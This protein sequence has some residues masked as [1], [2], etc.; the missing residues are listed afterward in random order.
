[1]QRLHQV[2]HGYLRRRANRCEDLLDL[3]GSQRAEGAGERRQHVQR[4]ALAEPIALA[5]RCR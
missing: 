3:D 5:H 4:I 2:S 1:L